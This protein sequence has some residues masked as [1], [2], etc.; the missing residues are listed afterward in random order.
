MGR[1]PLSIINI[2]KDGK[3]YILSADIYGEHPA[4]QPEG[5]V[6]CGIAVAV[7]DKTGLLFFGNYKSSLGGTYC[8]SSTLYPDKMWLER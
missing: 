6:C 3:L 2:Y 1:N 8:T 5:S 4:F 7:Y